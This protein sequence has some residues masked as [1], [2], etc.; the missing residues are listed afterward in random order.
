VVVVTM[1]G[2]R[3][4]G[5]ECDAEDTAELRS[6]VVFLTTVIHLFPEMLSW[7]TKRKGD[8]AR[9]ACLAR[10]VVGQRRLDCA[11]T[12]GLRMFLFAW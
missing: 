11:T 6:T 12:M 9:M 2:F 5:W 3:R 7:S 1:D 4:S 8:D 10:R